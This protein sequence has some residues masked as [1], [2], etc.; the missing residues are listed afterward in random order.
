MHG[1]GSIGVL[2]DEEGLMARVNGSVSRTS[3]YTEVHKCRGCEKAF[4]AKSSWDRVT[5]TCP[6]CGEGN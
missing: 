4:W 2:P 3:E 1:G 6:H 5:V